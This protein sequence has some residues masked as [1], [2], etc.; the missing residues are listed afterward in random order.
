MFPCVKKEEP[1]EGAGF[2]PGLSTS[3]PNLNIERKVRSFQEEE[4]RDNT[5]LGSGPHDPPTRVPAK[6]L[7]KVNQQRSVEREEQ[8]TAIS[9]PS[10]W[11]RLV[12]LLEE[13]A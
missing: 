1:A 11:K 8:I 4:R 9:Q 10:H 12:S 7:R 3:V 13:L 5:G 2:A 6:R